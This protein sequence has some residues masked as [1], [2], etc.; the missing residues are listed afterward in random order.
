M[1]NHFM[2]FMKVEG[3][4]KLSMFL[5]N[6]ALTSPA[7]EQASVYYKIT[8]TVNKISAENINDHYDNTKITINILGIT[9][10][11]SIIIVFIFYLFVNIKILKDLQILEFVKSKLNLYN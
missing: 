8:R 6:I 10:F 9:L 2:D 5:S 4:K 1:A 11:I 3:E 7:L